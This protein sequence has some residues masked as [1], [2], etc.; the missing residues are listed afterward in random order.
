METITIQR[1][2]VGTARQPT[3]LIQK[4]K[5]SIEREEQIADLLGRRPNIE[6]RPLLD[7]FIKGIDSAYKTQLNIKAMEDILTR[8]E[9]PSAI[10]VR[11]P[12]LLQKL[13]IIYHN[14]V[15]QPKINIGNVDDFQW[16]VK[17]GNQ[18]WL[19]IKERNLKPGRQFNLTRLR[20][21]GQ[22]PA[23]SNVVNIDTVIRRQSST[24][25]REQYRFL[26]TSRE[27][28][29]RCFG[30]AHRILRLTTPRHGIACDMSNR[31]SM[32]IFQDRVGRLPSHLDLDVQQILTLCVHRCPSND[33]EKDS[34]YIKMVEFCEPTIHLN[35]AEL[36]RKLKQIN[37]GQLIKMQLVHTESESES[38]S[39][40]DEGWS[41]NSENSD[42]HSEEESEEEEAEEEAVEEAQEEAVEEDI[43]RENTDSSGEETDSSDEATQ[44]PLKKKTVKKKT[45]KKKTATVLMLESSDDSGEETD[46]S[47]EATQTPLKKKTVKKKT[48]K[49]KTATVL[50][51]ESSDDSGE[52]TDSSDEATQTPLKKK[53]VKKKTVKKKTATVLMLESSDD[54]GEETDSSD[55]DELES[56]DEEGET[57]VKSTI[58]KPGHMYGD[59]ENDYIRITAQG[60]VTIFR[61]SG[62]QEK[63]K[64]PSIESFLQLQSADWIDSIF[65]VPCDDITNND[66]V[67]NS[68]QKMEKIKEKFQLYD[69]NEDRF[70]EMAEIKAMFIDA[71]P[72]DKIDVVINT[73]DLNSDK[74]LNFQEF[75]NWCLD[76]NALDHWKKEDADFAAVE[77]AKAIE[78][79]MLAGSESDTSE[80]ESVAS[81]EESVASEEESVASEKLS[82]DEDES[83]EESDSLSVGDNVV[84]TRAGKYKDHAGTLV[85]ETP[86]GFQVDI[87]QPKTIPVQFKDLQKVKRD[88]AEESVAS[89]EESEDEDDEERKE[90]TNVES[91]SEEESES[92]TSAAVSA[93]SEKLSEDEDESDEEESLSVGDN[94]VITRAGKYKDHA[95]TLVRETPQGFQVDIGQPK[96]IPVQFKDLQKVKRDAAEES[97]ASEEESE[98]EDDEERKEATNVESGSEEESESD[99]SAAV[100]AASEKLSEDE[101]ESDEELSVGDNVV[102]HTGKYKEHAGTLVSKTLLGFQV[103]IGQEKNVFFRFAA[104]RKVSDISAAESESG[105]EEESESDISAAVSVASEKS[106]DEDE[107]DEE[108]SLSV[109][110]KVVIT[111]DG[112]YK[113]RA[114]TLVRET[115]QGFQVNIGQTK[116]IF[117]KFEHLRKVKRDAAKA[118]GETKSGGSRSFA[119]IQ[120]SMYSDKLQAVPSGELSAMLLNFSG[121]DSDDE[122]NFAALS[123]MEFASD[124]EE[125]R[126]GLSFATSSGDEKLYDNS[127]VGNASSSLDF[128]TSE[129]ESDILK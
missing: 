111:R 108:E 81:E 114:G 50:M 28:Q 8:A 85:R 107:S 97:V 49:K 58:L 129:S 93:A 9:R 43:V 21:T 76:T 35:P 124:D 101:D 6:G 48:V 44:T 84:I 19:K 118:G 59:D 68:I 86:Q 37:L 16:E 125:A 82:E 90:A 96:T 121:A 120:N 63:R 55:A 54:S 23:L 89:E 66:E 52:E 70:V 24:A 2:S 27:F 87:G 56:S 102:I 40:S 57:N 105:S 122:L 32:R 77:K 116:P 75:L 106:E 10:V 78:D 47:D 14:G 62:Q 88:A 91:G 3:Q 46:S 53:T 94:V 7:R 99:T 119:E 127:S 117:V 80:E 74:R 61:Q 123:E 29:Q 67:K 115:R 38:D 4:L 128:A 95:G 110:D 109:G 69:T 18:P 45:V 36:Q 112:Q 11:R 15:I 41:S 12:M 100:S 17:N 92:D 104:L 65:E 33:A 42:F 5:D 22:P 34:T 72:L 64:W 51:L 60:Q 126:D 71:I 26:P 73:Y 20:Y 83:E 113:N 31:F 103:D 13:S 79:A 30:V 1:P 98:D 39:E 25:K